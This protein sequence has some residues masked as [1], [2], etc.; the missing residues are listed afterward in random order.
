MYSDLKGPK[1]EIFGSGFIRPVWGR[2]EVRTN[3]EVKGHRDGDRKRLKRDTWKQGGTVD[4]NMI[5]RT[6]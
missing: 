5:K 6:E 2:Q 4:R 3:K 1:H